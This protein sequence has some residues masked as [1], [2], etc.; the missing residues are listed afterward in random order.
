MSNS[1][2]KSFKD[3]P[4]AEGQYLVWFQ[5]KRHGSHILVWTRRATLSGS[6]IDVCDG[7]F[8]FDLGVKPL[9]YAPIDMPNPPGVS[10]D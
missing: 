5:K 1:P 7:C 6:F 2:W 8:G 10:D 9:Y 4:E 3:M